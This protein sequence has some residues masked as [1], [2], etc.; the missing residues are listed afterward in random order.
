MDEDEDAVNVYAIKIGRKVKVSVTIK[1]RK[2]KE[3]C[4]FMWKG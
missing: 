1:Q 4:I 2:I 3:K